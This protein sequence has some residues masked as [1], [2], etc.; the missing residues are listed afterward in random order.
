[1]VCEIFVLLTCC[2]ALDVFRDPSSSTGP[3]VFSIDTSN[4]F[5]LSRVANDRSFVPYVHQFSFQTLIWGDYKVLSFDVSPERFVWVVYA[6][7]WVG[8][9]PFVHQG[10]VMVL[11]DHNRVFN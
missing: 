4:S 9:F 11:D 1:M 6:F 2:T 7:D 8:P 5:I 10:M 3:E